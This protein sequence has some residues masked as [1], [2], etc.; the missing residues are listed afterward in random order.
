MKNPIVPL[1]NILPPDSSKVIVT[2]DF[3]RQVLALMSASDPKFKEMGQ[4]DDFLHYLHQNNVI[5]LSYSEVD[6]KRINFI[7]KKI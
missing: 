2:K 4:A 7:R 6:G 3:T 1:L 5:E